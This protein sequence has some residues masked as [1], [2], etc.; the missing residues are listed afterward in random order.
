VTDRAV[1]DTFDM[2]YVDPIAA[3]ARR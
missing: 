2:E 3:L 1:A